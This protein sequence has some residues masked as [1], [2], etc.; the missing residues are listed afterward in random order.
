M[1]RAALLAEATP[2]AVGAFNSV[3]FSVLPNEIYFEILSNLHAVQILADTEDDDDSVDHD[4]R[5]TLSALSQTCRSLR[6]FFLPHLWERIELYQGMKINGGVAFST[7]KNEA[8]VEELAH[9]LETPT[10]R[11]PDLAKYVRYVSIF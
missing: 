1:I 6:Q 5:F 10:K 8:I 9:Q 4:R 3:G 11:N 2:N 7:V